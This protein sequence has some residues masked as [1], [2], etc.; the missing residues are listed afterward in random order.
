MAQPSM[1][2]PWN[3]GRRISQRNSG[4]PRSRSTL[5]AL[6]T[7]HTWSRGASADGA[8][9]SA[10]LRRSPL[11]SRA[12]AVAAWHDAVNDGQAAGA[13]RHQGARE[14]PRSDV[15]SDASATFGDGT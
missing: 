7:V 5:R 10:Q 11:G 4:T 8:L 1:R 13:G 3:S 9:M 12:K 15:T 2:G 6:G 14:T